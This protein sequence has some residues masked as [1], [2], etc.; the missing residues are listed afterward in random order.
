[1][2]S[3]NFFAELKR[4]N[5]IR[6]AGLYLVGA[7]LLTQVASTVLPMFGAPE[8]LPRTIVI[9]LAIGFVP[10]LIFSWVFELTPQGLKRDEEV[11]PGQSIA[12]Q[13]ARWMDRMIIVVL[14]LA[15]GYFCVDKFVLAPRRQ[16]TEAASLPNESSTS[17]KS[18]AVLPF[19][20]LSRD[21][22]NAYFSEGI[23]DEILT[24]LAQVAD[25]KV[26]SRTSTQRYKGSP[27][28]L[29]EIAKQLGVTNILEGSVQRSGDQVRVN[30]QLINAAT[31]RHL[32]ADVYD[33]KLVDIF[34]VESE[35]ART[36]AETLKAKL[37]GSAERVLAARPTDNP[38][39]H[40]LYLRGRYFWNRRTEENIK[41]ALGY[42]QQAI[43][44][45]PSYA[46]AYAGLA[47][48]YALMP[49]Y[50]E[51][52]PK[53][54]IQR[55]LAAAHRALE[56]DDS[57]AEAHTALANTLV[58]DLQLPEAEREFKRA[59]A[60]NPN[61]ATAHQWYG[62]CLQA[63]GRSEE[64]LVQ[65]KLA[66]ELDPLSLIINSV[67][68]SVLGTAGHHDEAVQQLHRTLEMDPTFGPAQL[69]LGQVL[70][71]KG[72][73]A[74]ATAAYEKA[75]DMA[76]TPI[77]QAMLA[78]VYA[79]TGRLEDAGKILADLTSHSAHGY[80]QSY[81]LALAHLALG[82]KE[83]ALRFLEQAYEERGIQLVGNTG[84]L[85]ID[86][87]LDPL[88][89]DPRFETLLAKFMGTAP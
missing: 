57:S 61:Y 89:G 71:D 88:R 85:K 78:C 68:G 38:E 11:A 39:A 81:F 56:F 51:R 75:R 53:E 25:L 29:R 55:A 13:T 33:R 59:I 86:K 40:Q 83:E 45:D 70:E 79:R 77:R 58:D 14:L 22:D 46:L 72:N 24:R 80:I 31:D 66:H 50:S 48:C 63:E 23:Q 30:V 74:E 17:A 35:I 73:L 69:M 43:E 2:N 47:D 26:V 3:R 18:I 76:P 8:W 4:R 65:L 64:A 1:M 9:L 52:P 7:W 42:F 84:T 62:E 5:V 12:P 10:A 21:P 27:E 6:F 36:V 49:N 60:L 87:R 54:D 28:N 19:D 16:A 67:Y 15:L 44:Q 82:H 32:W 34:A 41:K 37:T 20:N